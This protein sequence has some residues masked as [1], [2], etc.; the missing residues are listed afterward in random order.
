MNPVLIL[1]V[2]CAFVFGVKVTYETGDTAGQAKC[3]AAQGKANEKAETKQKAATQATV[4]LG[5]AK[6]TQHER[7]RAALD[8]F[9]NQ[10]EKEQDHAPADPVDSCVLP[11]DRLRAWA[12][13]NAGGADQGSAT[14]QPDRAATTPA[15][16]GIGPDAG[17]GGKPQ[18]GGEGLP[19]AGIANVPAAGVIGNTP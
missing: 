15:A 16:S 10:L 8:S 9:F 5:A 17:P 11:P 13:A 18:G 19:P 2:L 7:N 12:D 3:Q 1:L 6:G 4:N 14:S